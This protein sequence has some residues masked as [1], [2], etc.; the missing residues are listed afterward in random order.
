MQ[1]LSSLHEK[2]IGKD[3][4]PLETTGVVAFL[5]ATGT[6]ELTGSSSDDQTIYN[7]SQRGLKTHLQ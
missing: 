5:V 7:E 2:Q 6:A 3:Y 4:G 1:Q